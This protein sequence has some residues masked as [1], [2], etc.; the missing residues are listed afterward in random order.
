M[1]TGPGEEEFSEW[2]IKLGNGELPSNE[3]DE[4]KLPTACISDGNLADE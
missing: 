2:L 3:N 1:R 4:I